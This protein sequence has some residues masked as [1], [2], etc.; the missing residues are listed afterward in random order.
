VVKCI[1]E[2]ERDPVK[3]CKKVHGRTCNKHGKDTITSSLSGVITNTDVEMFKMCMEEIELLEKQQA[4]CLTSLEELAN[5]H[6][7]KE[8]SLLCTIPSIQKVS[9][10][11]ILAET[12]GDMSFF[13]D[14]SHLTGWAGLRPRND[15]S[16]GKIF[17]R[18]TLHGNKYLRQI[19]VE[20]SWSAAWSKKTFLGQKYESLLKRMKPQKALL[21]ITRKM[22]V[23]IYNVLKTKQPFDEKRNLQTIMS[24]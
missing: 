21:A 8:I 1:I 5:K 16:A 9:A 14:A 17:S 6:F 11:C 20:I 13:Y 3:L 19:L 22:L 15:E 23:I 24:D 2:G 4:A 12:G 7:A 10:L 18:K